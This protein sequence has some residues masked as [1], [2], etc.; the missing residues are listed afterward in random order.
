[1]RFLRRSII[2]GTIVLGGLFLTLG[3]R[4]KTLN[5]IANRSATHT[6]ANSDGRPAVSSPP[7]PLPESIV[8]WRDIP[9]YGFDKEGAFLVG[10]GGLWG[11]GIFVVAYFVYQLGWPGV[12]H[13]G[14]A[15]RRKS[16]PD[17]VPRVGEALLF[18]FLP[19][20]ERDTLPGD[21]E[22]E[23]RTVIV[24]KF[25]FR[26]ARAW[27][28]WQAVSSVGP[29]LRRRAAKLVSIGTALDWIRQR[30]GL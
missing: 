28:W 3:L 15:F 29:V 18:F 14:T 27:Y 2:I 19:K 26:V 23:Y 13:L 12:R 25:G 1:M 4:A 5:I 21:L 8:Y 17:N 24:P 20:K 30:V 22:E 11:M 7:V 10:P 16:S 9:I 6:E